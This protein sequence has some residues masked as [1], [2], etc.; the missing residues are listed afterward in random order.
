M[1]KAFYINEI[2]SFKQTKIFL[3]YETDLK[4]ERVASLSIKCTELPSILAWAFTF[5]K[6]QRL[7]LEQDVNDFKLKKT[8][9]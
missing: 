8:K 7:T 2:F 6:V 5:H 4:K 1:S 3:K 9:N